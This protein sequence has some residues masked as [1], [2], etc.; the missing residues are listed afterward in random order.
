MTMDE[1]KQELLAIAHDK[2]ICQPGYKR[3]LASG[4]EEL[5]DYY[6]ENPDW[7]ME[8]GVPDIATLRKHFADCESKGVYVGKTFHGELLDDLQTYIFH[9]CK[10]TIKVGLNIDKGMIPMLYM[11]N[12]C[13][14]RIIGTGYIK[15]KKERD[16]SVVPIY[17]FG[18]NDVSARDN[19]YVKFKHFKTEL[20]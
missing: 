11:A 8:R 18:R 4:I 9:N 12:G 10:G 7:C 3:M 2:Q 19:R 20:I 14:M 15:P 6:V 13:R 16:R 1:V 17:T 5:V